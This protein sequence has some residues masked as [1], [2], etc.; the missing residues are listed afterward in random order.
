MLPRTTLSAGR[1]LEASNALSRRHSGPFFVMNLKLVTSI[2]VGA[3]A[4]LA[5]RTL[6]TLPTANVALIMSTDPVMSK[7]KFSD[8]AVLAEVAKIRCV[9]CAEGGEPLIPLPLTDLVLQEGG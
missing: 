4:F 5:Y 2:I 8:A 6:N 7:S 3:L 1:A 9:V